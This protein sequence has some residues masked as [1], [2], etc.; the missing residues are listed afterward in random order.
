MATGTL[1][2]DR[3]SQQDPSSPSQPPNPSVLLH[4]ASFSAPNRS[5]SI[6]ID[7][8]HNPTPPNPSLLSSPSNSPDHPSSTSDSD[9][10]EDDN[11]PLPFDFHARSKRH[12]QALHNRHA[13][14]S[15]SSLSLE[16][17]QNDSDAA[18][19]APVD[20]PS[21]SNYPPAQQSAPPSK[22]R[23]VTR[24]VPSVNHAAAPQSHVD[25]K[26]AFSFSKGVALI[27]RAG[28]RTDSVC[29]K[30]GSVTPVGPTDLQ[31]GC[32]CA[33]N[34]GTDVNAKSAMMGAT[35]DADVVPAEEGRDGTL[36][37]TGRYLVNIAPLPENDG[38]GWDRFIFFSYRSQRFHFKSETYLSTF[39]PF[40]AVAS[41][42][43]GVTSASVCAVCGAGGS[44]T[45]CRRCPL[46]FH[47]NC[48]DPRRNLPKMQRQPWFCN[49][50]KAVKRDDTSC[51]W[52]PT[53]PPPPLPSPETG[54]ARLIA[55]AR[56]GN[57]I[58]LVFNPTLFNYYRSQCGADWLRCRK[59]G[60]IRIAG[61]GVLT[62][63][64]RVPFECAYAFWVPEETRKCSPAPL[65]QAEKSDAVKTV[66]E[67]VRNR[68]RRRNALFF[69][70]F[71]EEDR[72]AYGFPALNANN[73]LAEEVIV[74][75]DEE[76][77]A[78]EADTG[79]SADRDQSAE[80][81]V[82]D[83]KK[84]AS[85]EDVTQGQQL[86]D[87]EG[88]V[89]EQTNHGSLP[90]VNNKQRQEFVVPKQDTAAVAS[91]AKDN[92]KGA[93]LQKNVEPSVSVIGEASTAENVPQQKSTKPV[94]PVVAG[95]HETKH[96][97]PQKPGQV[98]NNT[99]GQV[100]DE[101]VV[102]KNIH[103]NPGAALQTNDVVSASPLADAKE[104]PQTEVKREDEPMQQS[105]GPPNG[106][107]QKRVL[108]YIAS[109]ELDA[110]VEDC[111]TDMAL[112]RSD[113]LN[114]LYLAFHH[115]DAKFKRHA[116]RL[117][118]RAMGK[119]TSSIRF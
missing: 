62:E 40:A 86:Q 71:G 31:G 58:D 41:G 61:D 105:G 60:Q 22:R 94:R 100:S 113:A 37:K 85:I 108:P 77:E 81:N 9:G 59:C 25:N 97:M 39:S 64:V 50:C 65:T 96:N 6:T 72:T 119:D 20:P 89:A 42:M 33:L 8:Y 116:T 7:D 90:V 24:D 63:S 84:P 19:S 26:N 17:L 1:R 27:S 12:D 79:A 110:D 44:L 92:G 109:L 95:E 45:A 2:V 82:S 101:Q 98:C 48:I 66:E 80:Q 47:R 46:A 67:Y 83:S 112:E 76:P 51:S 52:E 55:D 13:R 69:Y 16:S 14:K 78:A 54:F 75:D 11:P 53:T 43:E 106:D 57:P 104:E 68:S 102:S 5:R 29:A 38:T 115:N 74:I 30:C 111:L 117:A 114:Q 56:D 107:L 15:S 23:K 32:A 21:T 118:S 28:G 93:T 49:A 35:K 3:F 73:E 18:D 103:T 70:R 4:P 10:D 34:G 99:F 88:V 36:G 91:V 87:K